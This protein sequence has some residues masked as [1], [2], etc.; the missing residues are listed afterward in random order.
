MTSHNRQAA[1]C[2]IIT[3]AGRL[4]EV[5][6][7]LGRETEVAVDLEMDSLH[8]YREK[9]CL[10]QVSTRSESWL[11]DP[12]AFKDLSPLAVPLADPHIRTV[13]HGADYDIRSLHRDF[14]IEVNSLFDTMLAARFLGITEFGLAALLK[15]RFAVE[16]NKKYQKAD[17]SKRPLSPEMCAYATADTAYLLPLYDQIRNELTEKGRL[18]WL[19]EECRLVCRARVTEKEGPLFLSCK[20][21]GKLK[22]RALAILEEL[23]RLRDRQARDLDRPAFKVISAETLL[24]VAEKRPRNLNELAAVKGMTPG[25]IHRYGEGILAAIATALALPE[26]ELPR[27]PRK[28]REEPADGAK[29]RLKRLKRWREHKSAGLGL[30]PGVVAP[31]WLLEAIADAELAS[32]AALDGIAGM[33][34]WQKQL[35]G[36]EIVAIAAEGLSG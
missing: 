21:A 17:W 22:G 1:A 6:S 18:S 14:G 5:A 16:L 11:I 29:E 23:L 4:S 32:I 10:I 3:D 26:D 34:E 19:E 27:F 7:M 28:L 12:L 15:A 35:Y 25:Q 33:R 31:N 8:H 9:V 20:G 13:L 30:E 24:E 36:E 2:E